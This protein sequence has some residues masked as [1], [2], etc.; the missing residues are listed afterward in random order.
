MIGRPVFLLAM[1][2]AAPLAQASGL[3]SHS[4]SYEVKLPADAADKNIYV[5][6]QGTFSLTRNCQ[7][8]TLGEV[9]QFGIEKG[10]T[11]APK[12]LGPTADRLEERLTESEPLDGSHLT[13][14][15]RLRLNGRV[16]SA[17]AKATS[18]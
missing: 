13:Y 17:T 8:W 5:E 10:T 18:A 1:V 15:A 6:G 7:S 12:Q 11:A 14:Q 16:T 4:V 9:Y 3:T 2:L